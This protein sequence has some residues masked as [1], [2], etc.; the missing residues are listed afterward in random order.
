LLVWNAFCHK[1]T[2]AFIGY[3]FLELLIF[4]NFERNK[5]ARAFYKYCPLCAYPLTGSFGQSRIFPPWI[6]HPETAS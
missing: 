4:R 5:T 6:S 2:I 3:K 1:P